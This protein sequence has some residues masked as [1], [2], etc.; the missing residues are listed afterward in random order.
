[1]NGKYPYKYVNK[2]IRFK[3]NIRKISLKY[4]NH[5]KILGIKK[6]WM[7]QENLFFH[8]INLNLI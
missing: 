5:K 6:R 2:M 8:L 7:T 4:S 3:Q 1:M